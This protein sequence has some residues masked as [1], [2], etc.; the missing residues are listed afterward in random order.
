ML[1]DRRRDQTR[2]TFLASFKVV[3]QKPSGITFDLA[4][5][6]YE[7]ELESLGPIGAEIEEVDA[8][9]E[10]EFIAAAQ[11]ADAVIAR[12]RPISS[13]IISFFGPILN[14]LLTSC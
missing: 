9:T 13:N 12:G 6:S 2:R 8:E 14:L 10:E 5:G 7:L 11:D 3:T 1:V 4:G